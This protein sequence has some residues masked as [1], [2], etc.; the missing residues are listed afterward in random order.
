MTHI[1]ASRPRSS[2]TALL[3]LLVLVLM[4]VPI[5]ADDSAR[6]VGVAVMVGV[7]AE[8][9]GEEEAA[10]ATGAEEDEALVIMAEVK[11]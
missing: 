11:V 3:L 9:A 4:L 10:V 2:L 1:P 8:L 6:L 5:P 7:A